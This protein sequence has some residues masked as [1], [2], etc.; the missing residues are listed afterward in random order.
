MYRGTTPQIQLTI[1]HVDLENCKSLYVT[2]KQ[3]DIEITKTKEDLTISGEKLSVT[4]SQDQT[5]SLKEG[6]ADIQVRGI[7]DVGKAFATS[8]YSFK[9]NRILKDGVIE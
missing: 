9:V 2:L 3:D 8:I 1:H 4:F 5:L 6:R 7:T